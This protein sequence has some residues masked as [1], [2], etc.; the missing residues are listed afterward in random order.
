MWY[1]YVLESKKNK[2][3][4]TGSTSDLKR[5]LSE[6]NS[7]KGGEYTSRAGPYKLIFYE[8]YIDK[9]DAVKAELFFKS[10]YGREVLKDKLRN[11]L[12]KG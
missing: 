10:G 1:V 7:K 2:R 12:S 9:R 11:Y 3:L 8:A 6:H 5:R 4:Y